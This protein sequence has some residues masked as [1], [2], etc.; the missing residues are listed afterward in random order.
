M[1]NRFDEELDK[2]NID[3]VKMGN[4]VETALENTIDAFKNQDKKLAKDIMDNDRLVND[5]ERTIESRCFNLMLRQQPI[6]RDLRTITTA[7]KVVT[8]LERIGDQ[9]ADISEVMLNIE[10]KHI[11]RTVEHIPNMLKTA[12]A[13]VHES[14]QAFVERD[15][16][17]AN[18]TADMDEEID[19]LFAEVKEEIIAIIKENSE[20]VDDCLDYLMIAKYL[21]RIGDHASN[22]CEWLDFMLTGSVNNHQII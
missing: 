18:A 16:N 9:S 14:I 20:S 10:G 8:D 6:A 19:R 17:R 2:L 4:M 7:L 5:M 3:I 13:L 15:L 22:I 12:K 11:Y 1:R 21:E